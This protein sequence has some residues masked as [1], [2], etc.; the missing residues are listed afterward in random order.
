[1]ATTNKDT[2]ATLYEQLTADTKGKQWGDL[3][4]PVKTQAFIRK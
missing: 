2:L 1:M 4:E 3:C